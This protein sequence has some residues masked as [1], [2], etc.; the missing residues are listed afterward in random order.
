MIQVIFLKS[1]N[2]FCYDRRSK[3]MEWILARVWTRQTSLNK[4]A[5]P[6]VPELKPI[7]H[8]ANLLSSEMIHFVAQVSQKKN[9]DYLLHFSK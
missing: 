6:H 3:R 5:L 9:G 4:V 1:K 7:L 8:T 2:I